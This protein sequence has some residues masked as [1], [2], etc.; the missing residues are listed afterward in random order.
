MSSSPRVTE[1]SVRTRVMS[2][3]QRN[4]NRTQT[5]MDQI[6]SGKQLHRPSDSPTGTVAALVWVWAPGGADRLISDDLRKLQHPLVALL[7]IIAGAAVQLT[8]LLLWVAA[9]LVLLRLTGKVLASAAV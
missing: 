6:S 7:L 3:L 1:S 4:L 2:S 9:P 5:A 8:E